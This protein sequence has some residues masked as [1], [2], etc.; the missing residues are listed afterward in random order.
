[1]NLLEGSVRNG[2]FVSANGV[3]LVSVNTGNKNRVTLGVRADDVSIADAGQGHIDATVYAFEN[4]GENTLITVQW[5]EQRII[6]RGD[7]HL[8]K[9]QDDIVG[10]TL[11]P[12]H[13]YLFDP[14][15][16]ERLRNNDE[17]D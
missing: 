8:R 14:D 11:D 17:V 5:G 13:L 12:Q 16:G 6:V 7:R 4:T 10:I 1:M 15:S 9:E 2:K 3:P